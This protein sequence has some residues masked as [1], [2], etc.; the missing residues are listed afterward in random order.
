MNAVSARVV[1]RRSPAA[2]NPIDAVMRAQRDLVE[3][4]H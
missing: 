2:Y 4:A 3:I 1:R